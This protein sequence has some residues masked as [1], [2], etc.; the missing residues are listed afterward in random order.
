MILLDWSR[1]LRPPGGGDG[2]PC[3]SMVTIAEDDSFHPI[4]RRS[5]L[6]SIQVKYKEGTRMRKPSSLL[7]AQH[8]CGST[9][10]QRRVD[11]HSHFLLDANFLWDDAPLLP[12][13]VS[14][15]RFLVCFANHEKQGR[16]KYAATDSIQKRQP[17]SRHQ[18]AQCCSAVCFLSCLRVKDREEGRK[19]E[20]RDSERQR[21][22]VCVRERQRHRERE[23]ERER[24]GEIE[25]EGGRERGER[26]S[27]RETFVSFNAA[28]EK[29]NLSNPHFLTR[30]RW[31]HVTDNINQPQIS[32]LPST[33][34]KIARQLRTNGANAHRNRLPRQTRARLREKRLGGAFCP[35]IASPR[36]TLNGRLLQHP[37]PQNI[38]RFEP[39]T[40]PL[41]PPVQTNTQTTLGVEPSSTIRRMRVQ[42]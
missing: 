10:V 26:E 38:K 17:A 13:L 8:T 6:V 34:P 4:A 36:Q 9:D 31:T 37:S 1:G 40:R 32:P 3:P 15:S 19:R 7:L 28:V 14:G 18:R 5:A 2:S 39:Q 11:R 27:E 25:R 41:H 29:L 24:E 35:Q 42:I 33:P 20:E 30:Q 22:S 12:V 16:S 21:E 23:R